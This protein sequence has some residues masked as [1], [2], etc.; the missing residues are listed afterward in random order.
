MPHEEGRN[1]R[2]DR[3]RPPEPQVMAQQKRQAR[4][5]GLAFIAP[6]YWMSFPAMLKGWFER[7]FAPGFAYRLTPEGRLGAS[8][9]RLPLLRQEKALIINTTHFREETCRGEFGK[10]MASI[11]DNW[12][13]RYPVVKKVE[14]VYFYG[15]D[16]VSMDERR[17]WLGQAYQLGKNFKN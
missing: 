11:I 7:V 9:G 6:L 12:G 14:H 17:A 15:A 4:A 2:H 5:Q 13:L 3:Y 10:A 16:V 8:A 1:E